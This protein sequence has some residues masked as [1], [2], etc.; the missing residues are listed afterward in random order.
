MTKKED[1]VNKIHQNYIEHLKIIRHLLLLLLT[2]SCLFIYFIWFSSRNQFEISIL[3]IKDIEKCHIIFIAP[4][5]YSF[6]YFLI[7][8][9]S[10]QKTLLSRKIIEYFSDNEINI[11]EA[12]IHEISSPSIQGTFHYLSKLS[13]KKRLFRIISLLI[14]NIYSLIIYFLPFIIQYFFILKATNVFKNLKYIDLIWLNFIIF[15]VSIWFILHERI[16]EIYNL[17]FK[18]LDSIKKTSIL[19][20]VTGIIST[21]VTSISI[22]TI[23]ITHQY[24]FFKNFLIFSF[25]VALSISSFWFYLDFHFKK[26]HKTAITL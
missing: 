4:F 17:L 22:I 9:Y 6:I 26:Q 19:S 7:C 12:I 3:G 25:F 2:L 1:L 24:Q 23:D 20:F 16:F 14:F 13:H 21:L 5:I 11:N 18:Y 15:F 10:Y 8:I